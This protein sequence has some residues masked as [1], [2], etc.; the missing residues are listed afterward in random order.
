MLILFIESKN[1]Y[2]FENIFPMK[3]DIEKNLSHI[4]TCVNPLESSN[5][6]LRR[7][8]R[9][10]KATNFGNDFHVFLVDNDP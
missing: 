9:V 6:E 1:A 3:I 7:S 8:K 10:R 5:I 2:F 4:D